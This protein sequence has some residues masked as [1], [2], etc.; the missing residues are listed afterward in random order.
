MSD[1]AKD[2]IERVLEGEDANEVTADALGERFKVAIRGGKKVKIQ[3][4]T[5]KKR[6]TAK[7]KAGLKKAQLAA[8]KPGAKKARAKSM[9]KRK[10]SGLESMQELYAYWCDTC[11]GI[12]VMQQSTDT[13]DCP[14]CKAD[15]DY[16]G[17][18]EEFVEA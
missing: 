4:K 7:Q 1:F 2:L 17:E 5:K 16:I 11:E 15:M 8:A 9:K 12:Q 10:S 13:C 3:I 14:E 6:M 18:A